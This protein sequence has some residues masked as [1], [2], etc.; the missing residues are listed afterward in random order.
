MSPHARQKQ[1]KHFQA[2]N[3]LEIA[4]G[5]ALV[6]LNES[7]SGVRE[8]LV[9]SLLPKGMSKVPCPKLR[10]VMIPRNEGSLSALVEFQSSRESSFL[11]KQ[12]SWG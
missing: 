2:D 8:C 6:E 5:Q 12:Y 11:S 7:L 10:A 9:P 3:G 4:T 1:R